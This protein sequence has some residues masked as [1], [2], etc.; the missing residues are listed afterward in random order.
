MIEV[1]NRVKQKAEELFFK[2]GTRSITM[3]EIAG[4]LG[5]SKKTIYLYY[6]DKDELVD[7]VISDLLKHNLSQCNN[8]K[9]TAKNAVHEVFLA[10]EI[11]KEMFENINPSI[12]YD[13]ERNHPEAFQKFLQYKNQYLFQIIKDNI[14]KGI[15]E[16]LY[17]PDINVDVITKIRLE[18]V[19]LPFN[20]DVFPKSKF[21]LVELERQL[22]EFYL[23]GMASLKGYKLILKYQQELTKKV[24]LR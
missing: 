20:Q 16:E 19:M 18:T 2:Y 21:N 11:V 6:A 15:K 13:I 23:F 5:I 14:L 8:A 9:K 7:S 10:M 1:K 22:V 24:K 3:D 17:R 12:L 4:Q